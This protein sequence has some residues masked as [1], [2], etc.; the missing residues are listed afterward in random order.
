[1]EQITAVES[2]AG[3]IQLAVAPV[4]LLAGIAGFLNVLSIRLGRIVDRTRVV[5]GRL[6][7]EPHAE[8]KP[9]LERETTALWRRVRLVN[10][11]IRLCVAA[12]LAVC[13]VIVSLFLGELAALNLS[14]LIAVLFVCAMLLLILGLILFMFE[15]T[16]STRRMREGLN[17]VIQ[18]QGNE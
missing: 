5:E 9:L 3:V 7:R 11:A 1:M 10:W 6:S 17:L 18:E 13:L 12:A 15:V 4:F 16:I 2:I 14:V 8:H